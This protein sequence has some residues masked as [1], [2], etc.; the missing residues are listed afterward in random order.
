MSD[1]PESIGSAGPGASEAG[2]QAV[3]DFR[4]LFE[5]APGLYLVLDPRLQIVGASDAY[6]SATMTAR[7]Q[8]VG[9]AIFEVFPDNPDDLNATG[10]ANLR[11]SLE[12]VLHQRAPDTMAVQKYDVSRPAAAGGGFEVTKKKSGPGK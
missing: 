4:A 6:L 3:V 9:R 5:S 12:R 11:A 1:M 2:V 8:I 10:A 7:E